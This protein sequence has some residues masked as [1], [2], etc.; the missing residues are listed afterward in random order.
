MV[1][2][3]KIAIIPNREY[4]D[5]DEL[6]NADFSELSLSRYYKIMKSFE[7]LESSGEVSMFISDFVLSELLFIYSRNLEM[8]IKAFNKQKAKLGYFI[9]S[10]S[11][12]NVDIK[13]H[14]EQL[15]YKYEQELKIIEVPADGIKLFDEIFR[16]AINK[17]PPFL[18][19]KK[20]DSGFK[21]AVL[22][23][24]FLE[25]ARKNQ[26]DK[27]ILILEDL[28][29]EDI[30]EIQNKFSTYSSRNKN[31]LQIIDEKGFENWFN[32]EYG[33]Y[34]ELRQ[35][36][37]EKLI[38]EVEF[39]YRNA[40]IKISYNSFL[41]AYCDFIKKQTRIY[42]ESENKFEVEVYFSIDLNF[43]GYHPDELYDMEDMDN[44]TQREVYLFEKIGENW[45]CSLCDY[46]YSI[47]YEPYEEYADHYPFKK[48]REKF[49]IIMPDEFSEL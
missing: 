42:Q 24:S 4:F 40:F 36:I 39:N 46:E 44:V 16:M 45:V 31:K 20:S 13:Q 47:Y 1:I 10:R 7:F 6:N 11:D 5:K 28:T 35:I 27:Y 19:H 22:L 9:K 37:D 32:E 34:V 38:P 2:T 26:Y 29:E 17:E 14:C 49:N 25:F 33:L 8:Q 12:L 21:D 18:K 30:L 48:I 23:L 41:I 3:E 43:S 15:K